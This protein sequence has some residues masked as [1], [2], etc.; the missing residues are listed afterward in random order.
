MNA[1]ISLLIA[2]G[3]A[4]LA[5]CNEPVEPIGSVDQ[6]IDLREAFGL[7]DVNAVGVTID[8]NT[9]DTYILDSVA[10]LYR[11]DGADAELVLALAD[12][13]E[14]DVPL[15]SEFTD[16]A[17]M[18]NGRFAVLARGDGYLLD[19]NAGTLQQW[20]CYEPGWMEEQQEQLSLNLAYDPL[21]DTL[22]SHAQTLQDG[23]VVSAQV[24]TFDGG[25]AGDLSWFFL[26]DASIESGGAALDE[27]GALLL[28]SGSTLYRYALGETSFDAVGSLA[29]HGVT[30]IT[31]LIRSTTDGHYLVVDGASDRFFDVTIE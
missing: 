24:G 23:E 19:T 2:L 25:G 9:E 7:D 27:D 15:R 18:G 5:G 11:L 16:V 26:D 31:G 1:R 28:G 29:E 12:F 20:F 21:T 17:S 13:P 4:A 22:Y 10:G 30:E 3:A 8:P 6:A 14:P